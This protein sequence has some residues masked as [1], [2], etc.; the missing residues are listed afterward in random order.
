MHPHGLRQ[1]PQETSPTQSST[2]IKDDVFDVFAVMERLNHHRS[3]FMATQHRC[4]LMWA[5]IF[6]EAIPI[7]QS[8]IDEAASLV[9]IQDVEMTDAPPFLDV[10][11]DGDWR[12]VL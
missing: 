3:N 8:K 4:A 1:K 7:L 11:G 9:A 6:E 5:Q 12:M 10:D 2:E